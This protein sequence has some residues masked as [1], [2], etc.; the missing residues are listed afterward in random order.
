MA[1]DVE[2][3]AVRSGTTAQWAAADAPT[4]ALGELGV[5][6][7]TGEVKV[8]N[9]SSAMSALP[10]SG[11]LRVGNATLSGGTATVSLASVTATTVIQLTPQVL[12]TVAVAKAL[13]VTSRSVGVSFTIT[14]ADATDT[15]VVGWV[16]LE[17]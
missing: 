14:S 6:L 8:G 1:I 3:V 12:G 2:E 10:K 13:A 15:S 4:L 7:T 17:V 16:A 11:G 5:N 9:G